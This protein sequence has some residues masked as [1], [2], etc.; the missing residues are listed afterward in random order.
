M[1]VVMQCTIDSPKPDAA[2]RQL[3][4]RV[5]VAFHAHYALR[6][7]IKR[8]HRLPTFLHAYLVYAEA[9]THPYISIII[10]HNVV[11]KV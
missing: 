7:A 1:R 3:Q 5:D 9:G 10:G 8:N 11:N 2:I 6:L 4:H